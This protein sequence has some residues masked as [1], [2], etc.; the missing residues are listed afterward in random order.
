MPKRKTEQLINIEKE[1]KTTAEK[2]DA[3]LNSVLNCEDADLKA[4]FD[5]ANYSLLSGGKRIRP[6][7]I[8]QFARALG[9][10]ED[11]ALD[12]AASLEMIHTYSLIHDDLPCMDNDDYR[13]GK[14]SNH[15]AFGEAT[16]LL[17]GDALLTDAFFVLSS[18]NL[19]PG[20]L[21][22]AIKLLSY[23]AGCRGMIGGQV[24]DM[25]PELL[26]D[27]FERLNKMYSLKTGAL[28][29]TA[30]KL[31][32]LAANVLDKKILSSAEE[33]ARNIG[34]VFQI[35]DDILDRYGD[36]KDLGKPVGSDAKNDKTTCLSFISKEEAFEKAKQLTDEAVSSISNIPNN[37]ILTSLAYFLLNRKK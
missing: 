25:T 10:N 18:A 31:G 33:Y 26:K 17:A 16:A 15:K 36:E 4:V 19:H 1:I 20:V 28:I 23:N 27:D 21:I 14:L 32:C 3:H 5:A 29:I 6:F 7:I 13:R 24:M 8:L 35:V 11:V 2:V 30:A 9:G 12:F 37:E 34:V 22:E